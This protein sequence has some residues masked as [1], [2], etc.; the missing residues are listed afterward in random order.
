MHQRNDEGLAAAAGVA[1]T[2]V[3]CLVST[4]TKLAKNAGYSL[5]IVEQDG[6][7]LMVSMDWDPNRL[8]VRCRGDQ[9]VEVESIG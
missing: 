7:Q 4:A 2:M 9:V 3:G 8:N 1:R 6:Q 5:R